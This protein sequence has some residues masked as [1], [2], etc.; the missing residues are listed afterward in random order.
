MNIE[1]EEEI[2]LTKCL[3]EDAKII[4]LGEIRPGEELHKVT[5]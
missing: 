2:D 1:K 3:K 4:I 5:P